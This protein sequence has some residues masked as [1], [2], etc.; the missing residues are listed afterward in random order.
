MCSQMN[1]SKV[2]RWVK[3]RPKCSLGA[4]GEEA[5]MN[6]R[7]SEAKEEKDCGEG[8]GFQV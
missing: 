8:F 7:L 6:T 3:G 5:V 2:A 4:L 1:P